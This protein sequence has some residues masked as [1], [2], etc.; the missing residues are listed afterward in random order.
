[1]NKNFSK[2]DLPTGWVWSLLGDIVLSKKG[3]KPRV[4]DATP[5]KDKVPYL[6]IKALEI[7]EINKFADKTSSIEIDEASIALVWDGSRSGLFFKG[8][9]GALGSTLMK[10]TPFVVSRDFLYYFL[11]SQID[12]V[13]SNTKGT[14]IPHVD[15]SM[16]WN[17][18]IGLPPLS[19]QSRIVGKLDELFS[20]LESTVNQLKQSHNQLKAYRQAL[21]NA[22]FE[23][24]LTVQWRAFSYIKPSQDALEVIAKDYKIWREEQEKDWARQIVEWGENGKKGKKPLKPRIKAE[25]RNLSIMDFENLPELPEEWCWVTLESFTTIT[26]GVAKGKKYHNAQTSK[27]PYLRVANVQDGYLDLREVKNI[28][29]S[30]NELKKYKLI[31]GDILYT[32]GG[33]KDKLGRGSIWR[34]EI[35]NCIHQN[36]VFRA[37]VISKEVNSLFCALYSGSKTAKDYFYRNAKQ[38]TNLASINLSVLSALPFPLPSKAEQEIIVEIIESRFSLI[39]NLEKT[40]QFAL[41]QS[42]ALKK[43]ILK[44]AFK[45][46]LVAQ[47]P[48]EEHASELIKQILAE[49]KKYLEGQKQ[50]KEKSLKRMK[51]MSKELSIE[52]VLKNSKEPMTAVRVWQESKHRDNIEEFY[53]EL[54]KI[55]NNL[56]E[57]KKGT[58]SLL[59]LKK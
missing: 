12:Y 13:R 51:K 22:A 37:R 28:Q 57:V 31:N 42:E 6:D 11:I 56:N 1:M 47:N 48:K 45:G 5:A 7:N 21:L 20:E 46:N 34:N 39:E 50:Q 38:T 59:S 4:L 25:S 29:V 33:D 24:K 10:I 40:I 52:D 27:V 49:K 9:K 41:I 54:K 23:G 14:G 55:Q 35:E 8:K 53:A 58:E 18:P 36:H 19:E 30:S 15:P 2:H 26:G 32:E 17:I 44:T 43:S 3:K 16:F